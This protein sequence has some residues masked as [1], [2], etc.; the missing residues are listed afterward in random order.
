M[1][2]CFLTVGAQPHG[3]GRSV[4]PGIPSALFTAAVQ[5]LGCLSIPQAAGFPQPEDATHRKGP[6]C[7]KRAV[8]VPAHPTW[9]HTGPGPSLL[10]GQAS[11]RG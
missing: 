6:W 1:Q 3:R 9:H 8:V 10:L 5:A 2:E 11:R 7:G 4:S